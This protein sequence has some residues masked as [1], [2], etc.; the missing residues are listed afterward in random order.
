MVVKSHRAETYTQGSLILRELRFVS[1]FAVLGWLQNGL[2]LLGM[3]GKNC[4]THFV[5]EL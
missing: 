1:A 3:Q 5:S 4:L 2:K